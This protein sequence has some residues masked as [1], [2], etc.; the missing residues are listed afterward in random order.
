LGGLDF[1]LQQNQNILQ[2]HQV[3]FEPGVNEDLAATAVFGSQLAG[4]MQPRYDGVLGMWYGKG[5]GV[6][7]TGDIFK[8]AQI[9][10]ISKYGG[11]LA[12]AGDDPVAK[13]STIPSHSEVAL[14]DAQMPVLYPGNVQEVIDMGRYGFELSRYSGSWVGFKF[15]TNVADEF[16]TAVVSPN[17][18]QIVLPAFVYNGR[19]WA[20]TQNPALLAPH[21]L[22]QEREIYEGRLEA[23]K[24]FAAA[25]RLNKITVPTGDAWLG[26]VAAGKTYYDVR[27]VL[28]QFG[29]DEAGLE[30][31]GIRL[32]KVGMLYPMEPTIVRQFARGLQEILVVEEKRSFIELFIRDVLYNEAERPLIVGK[33]DENG[34]FLV[35]G[36][37]ELD[38]DILADVLAQ[39][40]R[41]RLPSEP[42]EA[43]L[44]IIHGEKASISLTVN[45]SAM[46]ARTPY[47]CSGCPHNRS[48]IVPE[49]SIA[50]GGI[51]CHTLAILMDR[52]MV[53]L[54]Q[55]GGEGAQWVGAS[56]FSKINHIF[57]NIGDGT[58]FHS[59]SL[60]IRQA[61]AAGTN[62]TYKILYNG[63]VAMTG[64]QHADGEIPVPELTRF[65]RAEGVK[66]VI[67]CSHDPHKYPDDALWGD[68]VAIWERDKLDEAQRILRDVPGVTALIYD[69]PCATELRR[70]RKRGKAP[71]PEMRV[72]I[73]EA[74]CEGCGDCGVKSNCLSVFPVETE[75][76]RKTQIHQSS[77]NKDYTCVEGDC[78][79]FVTVVPGKKKEIG[80]LE[81][82]D[83]RLEGSQSPI[84]NLQPLPDPVRKV[85]ENANL[86]LMGIGGTGVVTINQ[87][88]ATA[89]LL[90]GKHINSL[91]QTGLSQ[92][93]G[94][95]VSNLKIM[96]EPL[97]VSN[98]VAK[99][100]ADAY[101]VFD[102][103]SGTTPDNLAKANKQRTVAVVSGSQI[104]TGGMVRQ[105]AVRFPQGQL[106]QK[107]IEAHT[108]AA[109]NAYIDAVTVAENLFGSH[110]PANI[111]TIGA[112]Y[113]AGVIP[114]SAAAIEQAIELNGVAV[115]ANKQAFR[116]GR[117]LVLNPDWEPAQALTRVGAQK[118]APALTSAAQTLVDSVAA[119]GE[120]R[121]L[122]I[123]RVP[124]LIAYQSEAYAR[125]YVALVKRVYEAEQW[126]VA[127]E[128]RLSEAVARY[129]FK[130]MAYK[131]EYEVARLH[132][133]PAF[134]AAVREQF[135]EG[136]SVSYKLH[137]P[138]LRALGMQ[139]KLS[140]GAW[141]RPFLQL[142][143]GMRR[144]RGTSLDL[145]GYAAVRRVE[146]QLIGEYRGLL[147]QIVL[148][149]T[150]E[151]YE[152]AVSLANLPDMIRGYEQIK[153][154]HV[155]RFRREVA[156]VRETAVE[157]ERLRD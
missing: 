77:C 46:P 123:M 73:N 94:P 49:G 79:A 149:L 86:Y 140:L 27:E 137:P 88:L 59:G 132:L 39:R 146:R 28:H 128:T 72:F 110:M 22:N 26:I 130:L 23:A 11:V 12:L 121:R 56:H 108:R 1:L 111:M 101:I 136:A 148:D 74:V 4:L 58:L 154:D 142:L 51:G 95:V 19:S 16:S 125:D 120:L 60:A 133:K 138:F 34:R 55:M 97:P 65:L 147:E 152:T 10:G 35:P 57:Q 38:A 61:V 33:K 112:A 119:T 42:I 122:L 102:V 117:M 5:P 105:T 24:L 30:R 104:P 9:A 126:A 135:G 85:P 91:D 62:I 118:V 139:K 13:S 20:P 64:G 103:L 98:K 17:R 29:L 37:S 131:D 156:R 134:V 68:G 18:V 144:L 90:D 87:I 81:V 99:G 155:D 3:V 124:E 114:V 14:Y 151:T 106:L 100:E 45:G 47:F 21:S 129:L 145:F 75:F 41:Q 2:E 50:G 15:V 66:R 52:Q 25:N 153:L 48:T 141:F 96:T 53:G 54:T 76:G 6:D 78:P 84:S 157:I 93:G 44:A 71:D 127:G 36:Y 80:R 40:L 92:K 109:D 7:R 63:A 113:Q 31:H 82:R 89:V 115:E 70:Q 8:H 83:W 43:R 69:Q 67:V 116:V 32:L 107:R 143:A 150:P